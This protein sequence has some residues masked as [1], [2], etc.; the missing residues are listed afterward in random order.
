M[1]LK[2]ILMK[3]IQESN[4]ALANLI[5]EK[6]DIKH[7]R[8]Q[9]EYHTLLDAASKARM[10]IDTEIQSQFREQ[11]ND[12]RNKLSTL[13]RKH[14]AILIKESEDLWFPSGTRVTIW[15]KVR[16]QNIFEQ[17]ATGTIVVF[18]GTQAVQV[19]V[20]QMKNLKLKAGD[21]IVIKDRKDGTKGL[22]FDLVKYRCSWQAGI[23]LAEGE[24][25]ENN[26]LDEIRLKQLTKS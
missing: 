11:E 12:I 26:K 3:Q 14:D 16:F 7:A 1:E 4:D 13:K 17:V 9:K 22:M 20:N 5:S 21:I 2:D 8:Y 15:E 25:I 19:S 10:K 24:T 18:D 23:F 6:E